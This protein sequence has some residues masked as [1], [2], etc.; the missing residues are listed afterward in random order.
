MRCISSSATCLRIRRWRWPTPSCA[1][2]R[3]RGYR[4]GSTDDAG[5]VHQIQMSPSLPFT[6]V[7]GV[8]RGALAQ[9]SARPAPD[10]AEQEAALVVLP[11][12]LTLARLVEKLSR[13]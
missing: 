10:A 1:P 13:P 2:S 11:S 4:S 6:D 5:C 9:R 12:E 8:G 7:T 3:P